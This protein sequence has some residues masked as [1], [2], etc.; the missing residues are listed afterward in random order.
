MSD[1]IT[2]PPP[3]QIAEQI[4]LRREEIAALKK[5][6]RA[7]KAAQAARAARNKQTEVPIVGVQNE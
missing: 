6:F 2:I 5:V 7:S 3:D 4:R 1:A